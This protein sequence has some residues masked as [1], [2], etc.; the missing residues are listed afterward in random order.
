M[1]KEKARE[2]IE[3]YFQSIELSA[4]GLAALY[5]IHNDDKVLL[6]HINVLIDIFT[7]AKEEIEG[8]MDVK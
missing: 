4:D 2:I 6:E 5:A 7:K 1:Y 8:V 3:A